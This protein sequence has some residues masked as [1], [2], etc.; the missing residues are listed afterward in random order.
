MMCS[1]KEKKSSVPE[2]VTSKGLKHK[3]NPCNGKDNPEELQ[4]WA[5]HAGAKQHQ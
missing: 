3:D 1:W 5:A 2:E 4:P